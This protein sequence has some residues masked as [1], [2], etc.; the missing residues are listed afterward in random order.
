M[1]KKMFLL[2]TFP[3]ANFCSGCISEPKISFREGFY[4]YLNYV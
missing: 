3:E 4:T 2:E 1:C